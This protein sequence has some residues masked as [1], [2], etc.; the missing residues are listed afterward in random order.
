[1]VHDVQVDYLREL[2]AAGAAV[3]LEPDK[4]RLTG[5][6]SALLA[7]F[8]VCLGLLGLVSALRLDTGSDGVRAGDAAADRRDGVVAVGREE[9]GNIASSSSSLISHQRVL[10]VGIPNTAVDPPFCFLL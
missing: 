1:M 5:V 7:C 2:A 6:A 10:S 4:V 8:F 3:A 9:A